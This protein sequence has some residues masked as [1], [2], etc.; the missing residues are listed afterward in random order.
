MPLTFNSRDEHNQR[1]NNALQRLMALTLVPGGWDD[2]AVNGQLKVFMLK[3]NEITALPTA[4]FVTFVSRYKVDFDNLELLADA[5]VKLSQKPGHEALAGHALGV[6]KHMQQA[7]GS[8]SITVDAKIK[9]LE[10]S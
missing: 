3:V 1:I 5:L 9:A 6:Y 8:F 10:T 7:S 2:D 4:E